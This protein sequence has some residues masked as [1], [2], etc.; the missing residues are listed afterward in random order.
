MLDGA[1]SKVFEPY[2]HWAESICWPAFSCLWTKACSAES[3]AVWLNAEMTKHVSSAADIKRTTAVWSSVTKRLHRNMKAVQWPETLWSEYPNQLGNAAAAATVQRLQCWLDV[4]AVTVIIALSR[5]M[6][7][8]S[9]V[10]TKM[11]FICIFT[12][13]LVWGDVELVLH[14]VSQAFWVLLRPEAKRWNSRRS[15]RF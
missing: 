11:T 14:H 15:F 3:P 2:N 8:L 4:N 6:L 13:V 12:A 5:H 9:E 1:S 7:L 10:R